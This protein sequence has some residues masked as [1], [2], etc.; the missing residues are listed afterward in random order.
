MSAHK[1]IHRFLHFICH[2]LFAHTS[3][4]H[5]IL[6]QIRLSLPAAGSTT[7]PDSV[8]QS[9]FPAIDSLGLIPNCVHHFPIVIRSPVP[10]DP[11]GLFALVDDLLNG[12]VDFQHIDQI[13]SRQPVQR[14]MRFT[15]QQTLDFCFRL[16]E[17]MVS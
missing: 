13:H 5:I 11:I 14:C 2:F 10:G 8:A 17:I 15:F 3:C 7:P 4:R 1:I 6:P 9:N 16:C 12:Q